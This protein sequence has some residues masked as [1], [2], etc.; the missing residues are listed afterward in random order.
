MFCCF[1][2]ICGAFQQ[3]GKNRLKISF[4]KRFTWLANPPATSQH[5]LS[6]CL[7]LQK[8]ALR[9]LTRHPA[10][11]SYSLTD[12]SQLYNWLC[13]CYGSTFALVVCLSL[14]DRLHLPL[15]TVASIAGQQQDGRNRPPPPRNA[16][17][18]APATRNPSSLEWRRLAANRQKN[19]KSRIKTKKTFFF[20]LHC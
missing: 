16:F 13:H 4:R 18:Y 14:L 17:L 3:P 10:E 12:C 11:N 1:T 8:T 7:C 19:E 5:L 15:L 6:H 2:S 9:R 20:R